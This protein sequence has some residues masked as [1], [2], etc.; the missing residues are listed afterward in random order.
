MAKLS[1]GAAFDV[2]HDLAIPVPVTVIAEMLG[3]EPRTAPKF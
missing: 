3:V 2:I 1:S